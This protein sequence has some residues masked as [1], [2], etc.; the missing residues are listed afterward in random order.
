[1]AHTGS[2]DELLR[3][4]ESAGVGRFVVFSTATTPGQVV[5]I[6]DFIMETCDRHPEFIGAGTMHPEFTDFKAELDRIYSLGLRGIKLHP[7]FQQVNLD[8]DEL[9][10]VFAYLQDKHMFLITHS[11][12]VRHGYSD[13]RRVARVAKMFPRLNIVA[14]HFGGWSDW[15]TARQTLPDLP[16]V[17]YDTSSTFG[18]GGRDEVLSGFKCF[19]NTHIFFGVDFPMWD[20]SAELAQLRS[21]GLDDDTLEDVLHR[22]FE[23][24]FAGY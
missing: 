8:C 7:D 16:N 1:M 11:G 12:D 5:K 13:P 24:F 17:Y 9:L 22:N 23:R 10:R 20:H 18:C 4:G 6:N 19:D 14:A 3:A 21:V 15:E 2:A